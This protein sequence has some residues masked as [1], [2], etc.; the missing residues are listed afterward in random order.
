MNVLCIGYFDKF[1]RFFIGIKK[2]LKEK[3]P[4]ARFYIISL[5]FS[6]YFYS[7]LRK[8]KS[9]IITFKAWLNV[10][11]HKKKFLTAIS[12]NSYK[13]ITLDTLI[14]YHTNL[15]KN[16]SRTS[17]LLQCVSYIDILYKKFE[18]FKPD[19]ILLIGDSRLVFEVTKKL[20]LLFH[21]KVYYIEQGP[22]NTTFFDSKGVNANHSISD[23][24]INTSTA[25][26][27]DNDE[28][29]KTLIKKPKPR[30]YRRSFLYRGFDW[31]ISFFF[32]KTI[33]YPPDLRYT[34]TYPRIFKQFK[35][36]KVDSEK[37]INSNVYLLVLQV[38]E[39]V[40]MIYHSPYFKRHYDIVKE[41]FFNLPRSS[42]LVI[43]EH[44]V[45]MGKYEKK[46]YQFVKKH[47]IYI[48]HES[49]LQDTIKK[50]NV[51][52]VNNSTV[53]IDALIN[54]KP[55]IVLGNSYYKKEKICLPYTKNKFLKAI[56]KEALNFI[57]NKKYLNIFLQELFYN[58]LIDGFITDND[59]KAAKIIAKKIHLNN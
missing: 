26:E 46:L 5:F 24:I 59:L 9:S 44:P 47:H 52:I 57:P 37:K 19:I 53:G 1:S 48:E 25:F 50:A 55:L 39:D 7:C 43:R 23:Y 13:N 12:K 30:P 14:N 58:H 16:I 10:L 49:S 56:L 31:L 29:I 36:R 6:G 51:V 20:A 32:E 34:D 21:V 2:E 33:L 11:L 3:R 28:L 17:L 18:T 45:Y 42:K 15:N 27:Q 41:V 38:P 4:N 54:Q 35:Q 40:N 8:H 22:Y